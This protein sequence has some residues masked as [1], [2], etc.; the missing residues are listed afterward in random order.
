MTYIDLCLFHTKYYIFSLIKASV[1]NKLMLHTVLRFLWLISTFL[2]VNNILYFIASCIYFIWKDRWGPAVAVE[3]WG[4]EGLKIWTLWLTSWCFLDHLEQDWLHIL[5]V[6]N[7]Q[8]TK[9]TSHNYACKPISCEG[10][11]ECEP[12]NHIKEQFSCSNHFYNCLHHH[13]LQR[14]S[15]QTFAIVYIQRLLNAIS[16]L[17]TMW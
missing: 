5:E 9:Y 13:K 3:H 11:D 8:L 17:L 7:I 1:N 4:W 10:G 6:L 16:H 12:L 15:N 2:N 14:W